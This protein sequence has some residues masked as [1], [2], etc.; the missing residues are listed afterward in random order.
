MQQL[1]RQL[2]L[3][4]A[5]ERLHLFNQA[6][7]LTYNALRCG[8]LPGKLELWWQDQAHLNLLDA[9]GITNPTTAA[10]SAG[11]LSVTPYR[12]ARR[13]GRCAAKRLT[14]AVE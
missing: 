11:T 6:L 3:A 7:S 5:I 1:A 14:A 13:L 4:K 2:E 12:F 9:R 10:T 8:N